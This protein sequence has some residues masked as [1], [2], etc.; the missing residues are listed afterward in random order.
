MR[1]LRVCLLRGKVAIGR[2]VGKPSSRL[3]PLEAEQVEVFDGLELKY[4]WGMA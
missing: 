4:V 1:P 3:L 2:A